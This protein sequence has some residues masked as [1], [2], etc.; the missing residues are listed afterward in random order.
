[1]KVLD[2][3][4]IC[5][6]NKEKVICVSTQLIEA[7]VNIDFDSVIR[8]IAGLDSVA[9][10]AGRCNRN[11]KMRDAD[12]N[13]ICGKVFIINPRDENLDKLP[14][15]NIGKEKT[16]RVLSEFNDD[17][18]S[19]DNDII[20]LKAMEQYY[21]YYFY[22]RKDHMNYPVNARSLI[23]RSDNLFNLLAMNTLSVDGFRRIHN[24]EPS[25][26]FRQS[27]MSAAKIFK[28]IDSP[29]IGLIVPY[30]RGEGI[31]NELCATDN[32]EKEFKLLKEAQR[33]SVNVFPYIFDK[34]MRD[35]AVYE[36]QNNA[37]IYCLDKR[38]YSNHYGL[39]D[40]P[41]N[42]MDILYK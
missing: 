38:Y 2:E 12:G 24:A 32:I 13:L 8:Y 29:A 4:K 15:I 18:A 1:M 19:F 9:Q 14:D 21:E 5:L 7:G 30:E 25:Q 27:F 41:V 17:P 26:L 10:A 22:E 3:I 20:G 23:G 37:G 28:A 31:I 6:D 36:I 42:E 35:G 34:L 40:E 11:G 33:Y 39:C 16:E